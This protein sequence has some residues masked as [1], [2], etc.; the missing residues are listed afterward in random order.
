MFDSIEG[1]G[2]RNKYYKTIIELAPIETLEMLCK[3]FNTCKQ[4]TEHV[5]GFSKINHNYCMYC[6]FLLRI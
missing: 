4:R 2:L 1:K 3:A 5:F 6:K